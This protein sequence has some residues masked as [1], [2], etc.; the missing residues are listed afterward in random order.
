M[1]TEPNHSQKQN[2]NEPQ[3][4]TKF[5]SSLKLMCANETSDLQFRCSSNKNMWQTTEVTTRNQQ[6]CTVPTYNISP[7]SLTWTWIEIPSVL[8]ETECTNQH[9]CSYQ[10]KITSHLLH[11]CMSMNT[12]E[13]QGPLTVLAIMWAKQ[14]SKHIIISRLRRV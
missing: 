4:G 8:L 10:D 6:A 3:Y 11:A 1:W 5:Y 7:L 14:V 2:W 12:Q 9:A 13:M